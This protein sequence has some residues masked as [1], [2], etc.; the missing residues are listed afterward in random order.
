MADLKTTITES[1]NINGKMQGSK[2][3]QTISGINEAFKAVY[4][5]GTSEVGIYTT[6]PTTKS[7]SQFDEDLVKYVRITNLDD[8]NTID[9]V[10]TNTGA[11]EISLQLK[12]GH[13]FLMGPH[14][15]NMIASG[16]ALTVTAGVKAA[17]SLIVADGDEAGNQPSENDY[18]E[19]IALSGDGNTVT[20][21]Y[22]FIDD[23]ASTITTG[24]VLTTG[25]DSGS[26]TVSSAN[27]GGIAV[28]G[29]M[30]GSAITQNAWLV[31]LKA[32]IEHVNGHGSLLTVGAVPGEAKGSQSVDL[33]QTIA[34]AAGNTTITESVTHAAYTHSNFSSGVDGAVASKLS[35]N[36]V[37]AIAN[38]E[39]CKVEV[40]IASE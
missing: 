36:A 25:D 27:D 40:F 29:N 2:S 39:P 33:T 15:E 26:S 12:A 35:V 3:T 18:Y 9:L 23:N 20:K 1:L 19:I 10:I 4:T 17:G 13:S 38:T 6:N 32:A 28:V 5:I 24:T 14:D 22:V 7:G 11:D 37:T 31:Q 21:R 30:T 8:V 34:G 16:S